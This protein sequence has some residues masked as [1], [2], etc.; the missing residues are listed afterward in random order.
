MIDRTTKILLG[1]IAVGLWANLAATQIRPAAANTPLL[2]SMDS[3]LHSISKNLE[4]IDRLLENTDG[5]IA[6]LTH[7][8]C[9]NQK[10]C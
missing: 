5:N 2:Q 3:T 9:T 8:V 7:G 6:A 4:L 10:I 1:A